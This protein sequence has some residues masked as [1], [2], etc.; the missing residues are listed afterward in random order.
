MHRL[1]V[2]LSLLMVSASGLA[3]GN[4]SVLYPPNDSGLV[5]PPLVLS[6]IKLPAGFE[7]TLFAKDVANARSMC[8]GSNGTVFVGTRDAGL[9]YAL[10]DNDGDGLAE[11]RFVVAKD[12][13]MPSGVTFRN[14]SLYV[15]AVDRILRLDDIE[16]R[17]ANPPAPVVVFDQFPTDEQHGWRYIAF[18][19]DGKLYVSIGAPC[20]ICESENPT[21]ATITRLNPD[22][23]NMEVVQ[24]GVRNSV[25]FDWR[26][27]TTELWFT[28]NGRDWLGDEK[29]HAEL[30]RATQDGLHFGFPYCH[31]GDL[32]DP[33]YG[34]K[35]P[36]S[37]FTPPVQRLGAHVGPHGM[38]FCTASNWP[39][40]YQNQV[41][42]AEHGSWNSIAKAGYRLTRV[43]LDA[44][45]RSLG[46][47][48]FAE[49]WLKN[50]SVSGRPVDMK[51]LPDG[52]LLVSD[53]FADVI[54]RIVWRG[55]VATDEAKNGQK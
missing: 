27:G 47:E 41:L 24:R 26:P 29:P 30:N 6:D 32:P 15:A 12:L 51:W 48:V 23:T 34:E 18:G 40:D 33:K 3:F 39:A 52:S 45:G 19:P 37:A 2:A 17:L 54:Y 28:D 10:R 1:I 25:G 4:T 21:H 14:G 50:G 46:T 20:N 11:E 22:G 43:R 5:R 49:G 9:V 42:L 38:T 53:D 7:L 44:A 16:N 8:I 35:Q 31:Q 36:C 55:S 13:R